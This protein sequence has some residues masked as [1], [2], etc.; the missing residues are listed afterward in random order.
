MGVSGVE[1]AQRIPRSE[2]C[3]TF[4]CDVIFHDTDSIDGNP[5]Y[6]SVLQS[7]AVGRNDSCP[8]HQECALG[9]TQIF[10]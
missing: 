1:A 5:D 6:V 4:L 9:K 3:N 2:S 8:G 10:K 7:K